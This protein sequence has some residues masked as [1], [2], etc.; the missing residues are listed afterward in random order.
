[1]DNKAITNYN[2]LNKINTVCGVVANATT[3]TASKKIITLV[4]IISNFVVN[5]KRLLH[6]Q[7]ERW[8]ICT[9]CQ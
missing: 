8:L 5:E 9:Q 2:K 6:P 7:V 3:T 1:M 4:R